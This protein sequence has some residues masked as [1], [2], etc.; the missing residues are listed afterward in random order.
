[1]GPS[2]KDNKRR[3]YKRKFTEK[4]RIQNKAAQ[5]TYRKLLP[6]LN[7]ITASDSKGREQDCD[8][9]ALIIY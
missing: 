6:C 1:M 5:Q 7:L 9:C 2:P 8:G 4:R 3:P